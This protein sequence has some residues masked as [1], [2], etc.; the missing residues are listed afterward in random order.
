MNDGM[1]SNAVRS[2]FKDS[3]GYLWVGTDAGLCRFDG[4]AFRIY[5]SSDGFYGNR[6]WSIAEDDDN[7]L[8]FGDYGGGLWKFDGDSFEHFTESTGLVSNKIRCLHYSDKW[9]MLFIGTQNGI[10]ILSENQFANFNQKIEFLDH[11]PFVTGFIEENDLIYIYTFSQENYIY[12]PANK[13]LSKLNLNQHNYEGRFI[14]ALKKSS[15]E[16][17]FTFR[18]GLKVV[19]GL[20]ATQTF[21]KP[22]NNPQN[23]NI[24]QVFQM[25]ED[26]YGN[27]WM[28]SW[29]PDVKNPGGLFL[30]DGE[31]I[32]KRNDILGND[33]RSGWCVF[34]D[35]EDKIIWFGTLDMGLFMI[36]ETMFE[37]FEPKIF[38]L[39]TMNVTDINFD[40]NENMFILTKKNLIIWYSDKSYRI[41]SNKSFYDAYQKFL[42]KIK[43]KDPRAVD[44][45]SFLDIIEFRNMTFQ[46]DS[47]LWIS[48]DQ[49][50]FK[51]MTS[52]FTID[53]YFKTGYGTGNLLFNDEGKLCVLNSLG[54]YQVFK[55]IEIDNDPILYHQKAEWPKDIS[56]NVDINDE[57]WMTSYSNGLFKGRDT[58]FTNYNQNNTALS[59]SLNVICEDPAG[60]L[61]IGA[62]NGKLYF[63][64]PHHDSF[65]IANTLD[66]KDGLQGN[67]IVWLEVDQ[68]KNLWVGTN[69][70]LNRLNLDELYGNNSLNIYNFDKSEGYLNSNVN[71]SFYDNRESIWLGTDKNLVCLH[72]P[73]ISEND[74]SK[75]PIKLLNYSINGKQYNDNEAQLQNLTF[76]Q[77]FLSF[78]F[79][80]INFR[81]PEK[82]RFRYFCSDLNL[83]M[84]EFSDVRKISFPDLQPGKYTLKVEA[85][86]INTGKTYQPLEVSINIHGPFWQSWW[87]IV[88][89]SSISVAI[90]TLYIK[91]RIYQTKKEERKKAE[92][93]KQLAE[94]E[95]KALLAQMNPHFTFNAINSIQ[96]YILDNDVDKALSYLSEFSKIIRQ[97]LENASKE[98]V[99]LAEE[100]EYIERYLKLEQMRFDK[101]F[102]FQVDIDEKLDTETT[103]IPPMIIQP[104]VE[105][106]IKH[107]L[108]H[109]K[110]RGVLKI[111]FILKKPDAL[112]CIIEDNGIGRAASRVINQKTRRNHNGAGMIITQNRMEKLKEVYNSDL[113]TVQVIDLTNEKEQPN[114]TRVE[115]MLPVNQ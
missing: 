56:D 54:Y 70:G 73:K 51:L 109:I 8:W 62:N 107:G 89:L 49:G 4:K 52:T 81:N 68:N 95:M 16:H 34:Y 61:I 110:G 71:V 85:T 45:S 82:D 33:P 96:N 103:Q 115:I 46:N 64:D 47:V 6:I 101:Q 3:E 21:L 17:L 59:N 9:N 113:Y 12:N 79:D 29:E 48:S 50:I 27:I 114:G 77:S 15:G 25:A 10:S 20:N 112:V 60:N 32:V 44:Y 30:F 23:K 84:S 76:R 5:G 42:T 22:T 36:Q 90:V 38:G 67:S 78:D 40:Y 80:V 98:F 19:G 13:T 31:K 18:N 24:G 94:L 26:D 108:R 63:A 92:I 87:F 97:T 72:I 55:N 86:N 57:L 88:L 11:D 53:C 1:P 37:Y 106:A 93:S 75:V 104:Y 111:E 65:K 100:T 99:T 2:I 7:Q 91:Y 35:P 83:N 66:A 43:S 14:A 102:T 41:V 69:T 58:I 39:E 105:N 28:A 74:V